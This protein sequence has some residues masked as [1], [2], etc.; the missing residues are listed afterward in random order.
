MD[1]ASRELVSD[2]T[3]LGRKLIDEM[4]APVPEDDDERPWAT[5]ML[6]W[7]GDE[8]DDE[9]V[10]T[11]VVVAC[12][13]ARDDDERWRLVSRRRDRGDDFDAAAAGRTMDGG[14]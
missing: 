3:R 6:R 7:G 4:R 1:E 10:W 9:T 13:R 12:R 5:G 8:L 11:A 2:P 14:A